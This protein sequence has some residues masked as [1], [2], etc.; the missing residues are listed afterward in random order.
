MAWVR[1]PG[2]PLQYYDDD[3]LSTFA[4]AIGAPVRIDSNTSQATR[5][6]YAR[7]CVEV[8]L[9][10]PLVPLVTIQEEV[11]RVQY[12]G[13]HTICLNCGRFGH[14]TEQCQFDSSIVPVQTAEGVDPENLMEMSSGGVNVP[15]S[16]PT[17]VAPS[18]LKRPQFGEWMVVTR[19]P[20][21]FP[22]GKPGGVGPRPPV[23]PAGNRFAVLDEEGEVGV[24]FVRPVKPTLG[25]F[26]SV[27][28]RKPKRVRPSEATGKGPVVFKAGKS[29]V[30]GDGVSLSASASGVSSEP[31]S[32]SFMDVVPVVPLV[33]PPPSTVPP[34][35]PHTGS[36]VS[37][38]SGVVSK[39]SV[40]TDGLQSEFGAPFI[41]N[42]VPV[43]VEPDPSDP[44]T[45]LR[46]RPGVS[47]AVSGTVVA[48]VVPPVVHDGCGSLLDACRICV[49]SIALMWFFLFEVRIGRD[50]AA[51]VST[52]FGFDSAV[53]LDPGGSWVGSAVH[54]S[55]NPALRA[56]LWE[57]LQ[58]LPIPEGSPWRL[59]GDF[60]DY[61]GPSDT[62]EGQYLVARARIF[63]DRLDS[64]HLLDLGF[65]RPPFTWVRMVG[66]SVSMQTRL[67]RAVATAEWRELFPDASVLHLPRVYSDHHP[68][69]L[70][71]DGLVGPPSRR[72]FRFEAAWL[73]HAQYGPLVR[74]SWVH[75]PGQ[76]QRS[77]TRI[78]EVSI[79][80]NKT[81]FGNIFRRKR[82]LLGRISGAQRALA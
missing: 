58:S 66:S 23:V 75:Q 9:S 38:G 26:V 74:S 28:T 4:S 52:Q 41:P 3:L 69:L 57:H 17:V 68:L 73:S 59:I 34:R 48:G 19:P 36:V 16:P 40:L 1:L 29:G 32:S 54:G 15:A 79:S 62:F 12:E 2:L 22:R 67:D 53:R 50:R 49:R 35:V 72:P 51:R 82:W 71:L 61:S 6:L 46:D 64:L 81:T 13:L 47:L 21:S 20:R 55:P 42:V 63:N 65:S 76:F 27:G 37:V 44:V 5:A 39:E 18:A 31:H 24:S 14:T 7:R 33:S 60:N 80:F 45:V 78:R 77:L 56:S 25:D 70:V 43:L 8:D 30:Q 11:F 10:Q